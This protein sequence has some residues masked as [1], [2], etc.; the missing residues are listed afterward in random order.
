MDVES[1]FQLG[2]IIKPH[3]IQGSLWIYLDTDQPEEYEQLESVFV[4]INKKLIPFF[5][6]SIKIRKDR[7]IVHFDN[8]DTIEEASR[9]K[10]L[11]L[12][13]PMDQLSR[14][15]EGQFYYHDVINYLI[16]NERGDIIGRIINVLELNGNDLFSVD[17]QGREVLIPVQE[18]FILQ[19]DPVEGKIHMKL[20][21]G[22]LEVYLK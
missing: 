19:V 3:G 12:Y 22:L 11:S 7:A 13:L 8:V 15:E 9:L 14:L 4:E 10:G 2:Y 5:I 16:V 21:E 20:P 18:D 17:H 1:C 6:N